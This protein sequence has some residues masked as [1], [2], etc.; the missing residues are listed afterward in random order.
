[1]AN[2]L[3]LDDNELA[4]RALRGILGRSRNRCVVATDPEA[5]YQLLSRVVVIDLVVVEVRLKGADG[6]AFLTRVRNDPVFKGLPLVVYTAVQDHG[7]AAKLRA[8][9]LQDYHIKPYEEDVIHAELARAKQVAW[10]DGHFEED[11]SFCAQLGLKPEGL[12]QARE[13]L[14]MELK[15]LV[16]QLEAGLKDPS[17]RISSGGGRIGGLID[18]AL[19]AG[20]PSL[21]DKLSELESLVQRGE[22][23]G[24]MERAIAD[25][26]VFGRLLDARLHPDQVPDEL[27]TEAEH[28]EVQNAQERKRWLEADVQ[29]Q[30]RVVEPGQVYDKVDALMACPVIDGVGAEFQMVA[31][32]KSETLRHLMDL[33]PRDPGLAASVL[34]A[35]NR[36]GHDELSGVVQDPAVAV[37]VLGTKG[38]VSLARAL[39][40]IEER[41]LNAPP[42]TWPQFW[43]FQMGVAAVALHTAKQMEFE[44]IQD[45]VYTAGLLQ[46]LGKLILAGIYPFG[47]QA[48]LAHAKSQG[49]TLHQAELAYMGCNSR[50]LAVR[51]CERHPLPERYANVIRWVESPMDAA[52][53]VELVAVV[54]LA[55]TLCMHHHVGFCGDTPKDACPPVEETPA[56]EVLRN[57]V[58]PSFNLKR[59]DY[60]IHPY[61]LHLKQELLGR[62][63]G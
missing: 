6:A 62:L 42:F 33:A 38:V 52:A 59:F 8:L 45:Y 11:K 57:R 31:D 22:T 37:G 56:W 12:R 9:G 13:G 60:D 58:Y 28:K 46:D 35:A 63:H 16:V 51:F 50:E 21:V 55:R 40:L 17:C 15:R 1:M 7:Q 29:V 44:I 36:L 19:G 26:G 49:I 39:P 25:F 23:G 2:V 4:G 30:G 61:C 5:A 47:F 27:V 3:L 10:R 24:G 14:G 41:H 43:M 53:D 18:A 34:V 48:M 20:F 32:M 54:S